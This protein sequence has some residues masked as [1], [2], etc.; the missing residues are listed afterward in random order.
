LNIKNVIHIEEKAVVMRR[1]TRFT[2]ALQTRVET[3]DLT[4]KLELVPD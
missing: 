2:Q 1:E 3:V 4:D